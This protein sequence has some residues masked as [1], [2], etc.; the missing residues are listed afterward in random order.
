MELFLHM[1]Q[2]VIRGFQRK[3]SM[4]MEQL[5]VIVNCVAIKRT[6]TLRRLPKETEIPICTLDDSLRKRLYAEN[7]FYNEYSL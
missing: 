1:C 6:R 4:D 5:E 7:R 2:V 3:K